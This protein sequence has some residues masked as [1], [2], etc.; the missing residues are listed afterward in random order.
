[1]IHCYHGIEIT[2]ASFFVLKLELQA[3]FSPN[4]KFHSARKDQETVEQVELK[5]LKTKSL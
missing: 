4:S 3:R 1:M 5:V 2:D